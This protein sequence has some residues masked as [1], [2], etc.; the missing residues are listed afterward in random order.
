MGVVFFRTPQW[1]FKTTKH[2]YPQNRHTHTRTRGCTQ[3]DGRQIWTGRPRS[4]ARHQ[5][6]IMLGPSLRGWV[7][8]ARVDYLVPASPSKNT[9]LQQ[10]ASSSRGEAVCRETVLTFVT[11]KLFVKKAE[12]SSFIQFSFSTHHGSWVCGG[13]PVLAPFPLRMSQMPRM[14]PTSRFSCPGCQGLP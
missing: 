9:A 8:E 10:P 14:E 12:L 4:L 6:F 3:R 7:L 5:K 1:W 11:K 2:G 13:S